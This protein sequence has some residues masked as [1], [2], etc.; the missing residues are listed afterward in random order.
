M[1]LKLELHKTVVPSF[2]SYI[3]SRAMA[4]VW[5][6]RP[7]NTK[8]ALPSVFPLSAPS[9]LNACSADSKGCLLQQQNAKVQ[10]PHPALGTLHAGRDPG[11]NYLL[12]CSC[13]LSSLRWTLVLKQVHRE[14]MQENRSSILGDHI[15]TGSSSSLRPALI[16][17]KW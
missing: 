4:S 8:Q 6:L 12:A 11:P 13:V 3:L 10:S 16:H 14:E 5:V 15:C 7:R 2:L 9:A 1:L 17:K